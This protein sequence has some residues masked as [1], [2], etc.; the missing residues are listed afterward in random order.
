MLVL[1][2]GYNP[3]LGE[4][5]QESVDVDPSV[6]ELAELI[7]EDKKQI[8]VAAGRVLALVTERPEDAVET[9]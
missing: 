2:P 5:Y 9:A 3:Q 4:G 8:Q 1:D 7:V 6:A